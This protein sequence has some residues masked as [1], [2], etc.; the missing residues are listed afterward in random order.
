MYVNDTRFKTRIDTTLRK[1]PTRR[2]THIR[3][4]VRNASLIK[5]ILEIGYDR[6]EIRRMAQFDNKRIWKFGKIPKIS[7]SPSNL[8]TLPD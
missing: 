5:G 4:P 1:I 8:T 3:L 2:Y 7:R 6:V